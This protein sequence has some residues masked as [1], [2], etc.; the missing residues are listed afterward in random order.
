MK[1]L[2]IK[3]LSFGVCFDIFYVFWGIV[4]F[5]LFFVPFITDAIDGMY[6]IRSVK[7][8]TEPFDNNGKCIVIHIF[9]AICSYAVGKD[10]TGHDIATVLN[11]ERKKFLLGFA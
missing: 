4:T 1:S 9:R 11:E 6:I 2:V 8:I 10:I 3:I 7:F 5:F